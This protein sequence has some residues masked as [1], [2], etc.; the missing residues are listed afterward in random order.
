MSSR[1]CGANPS[2]SVHFSKGP[3]LAR[4]IQLTLSQYWSVP[5]VSIQLTLSQYLSL[6]GTLCVD[7]TDPFAIFVDACNRDIFI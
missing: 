7:S 1:G 4:E 6:V 2:G 3:S 5:C